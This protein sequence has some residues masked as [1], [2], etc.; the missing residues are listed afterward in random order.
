[1]NTVTLLIRGM[2]CASCELRLRK[3]LLAVP[4]VHDVVVSSAKARATVTTRASPDMALLH[5]AVERAGYGIGVDASAQA[6]ISNEG[7][8]HAELLMAALILA[9]FFITAK[10]T[11]LLA[12]ATSGGTAASAGSALLLGVV[13]GFSTCMALVGG[14]VLGVA[15]RF[16]QQHPEASALRSLRPHAFFAIGRIAGF[17]VL[18]GM[19]GAAG[20]ILLPSAVALGLLTMAVAAVMLLLGAQLTGISPRLATI[21]FT[22]PACIASRLGIVHADERSYSDRGAATLGALTFFLPCGFTQMMQLAAVG[23]GSAGAGAVLLGAFAIGTAPG[24]F[25]IGAI[26][27]ALRGGARSVGLKV[28][29]LLVIAFGLFTLLNGYRL[30][31]FSP[32]WDSAPSPS[33]ETTI[34]MQ[35]GF[36]IVRMHQGSRGYTPNSFTVQRGVP[37]RWVIDVTDPYSCSASISL[38]AAGIVRYFDGPGQNVI[39]FTPERSGELRFTCAMGMFPGRFTVID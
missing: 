2:H 25:G 39:E 36:Q 8:V 21:R 20:D 22:I 28:A 7:S 16:A 9:A 38:P 34:E 13:A 6:W 5:A 32:F 37:V 29:G 27:T 4:G 31:G 1:M 14:L 12:L 24:L 35:D 26:T 3:A 19:L 15:A 18:G 23:S 11:G 30:A 17:A 33:V 10:A